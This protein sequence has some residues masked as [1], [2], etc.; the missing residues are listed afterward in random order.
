MA[1]FFEGRARHDE[2]KARASLQARKATMDGDGQS[3]RQFAE[4]RMTMGHEL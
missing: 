4:R 1:G 3:P 2:Q